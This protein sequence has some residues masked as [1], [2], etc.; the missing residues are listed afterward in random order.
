MPSEAPI[1]GS[2]GSR[3]TRNQMTKK[4]TN[5]PKAVHRNKVAKLVRVVTRN[6]MTKKKRSTLKAVH[7]NKMAKKTA[8]RVTTIAMPETR[9][10]EEIRRKEESQNSIATDGLPSRNRKARPTNLKIKVQLKQ[11][12]RYSYGRI[13]ECQLKNAV[14]IHI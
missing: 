4:E 2:I 9:K 10:Q 1:Q 6:K 13:V 12:E 5:T 14:Y 11:L 3:V 8:R 7:R